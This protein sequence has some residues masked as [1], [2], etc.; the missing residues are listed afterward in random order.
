MLR[1]SS[2]LNTFCEAFSCALGKYTRTNRM[3]NR[4]AG[5]CRIGK[6]FP[7]LGFPKPFES[8]RRFYSHA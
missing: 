2:L 7:I 3:M 5:Y 4:L 6:P 8:P 1:Y